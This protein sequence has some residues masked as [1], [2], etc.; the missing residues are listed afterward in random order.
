MPSSK[1]D[2]VETLE[3]VFR[4]GDHQPVAAPGETLVVLHQALQ[5]LDDAVHAATCALDIALGRVPDKGPKR[6]LPFR[7]LKA[8]KEHL[9]RAHQ[10]DQA[11][12]GRP[13]ILDIAARTEEEAALSEAES[14]EGEMERGVGVAPS[15]KLRVD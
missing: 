10:T 1:S 4:A 11:G 13:S 9:D 7:E 6:H 2:L 8:L 3:P 14:S 5:Q 12:G 15:G